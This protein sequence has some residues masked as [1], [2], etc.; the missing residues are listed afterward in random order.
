MGSKKSETKQTNE[1]PKW[2]APLFQQAAGDAQALYNSKTGYNTYTGPTQADLSA[3]TLTGMNSAL[4]ATGY[5][6]TPITNESINANI[7][8]VF[9]I[10]QQ[11]LASRQSPAPAAAA[12]RLTDS[13][14]VADAGPGRSAL[15]IQRPINPSTG[16]YMTD[17]QAVS[18]YRNTQAR[19][20]E[21]NRGR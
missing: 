3:P 4:A 13:V 19:Q 6:G 1:P 15:Y 18:Q 10:M 5:T 17:E 2:A 16:E 12:S 8:D 7:P 11:A 21:L 9:S 20:A 14:K